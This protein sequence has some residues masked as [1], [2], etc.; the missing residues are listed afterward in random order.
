MFYSLCYQIL[1]HI[2]ASQMIKR[3]LKDLATMSDFEEKYGD[4]DDGKLGTSMVYKPYMSDLK[5]IQ[6]DADI[7]RVVL[8][9]HYSEVVLLQITDRSNFLDRLVNRSDLAFERSFSISGSH[10][11]EKSEGI[12]SL[13]GDDSV[14]I[15]FVDRGLIVRRR[16]FD[17][18][19]AFI[20]SISLTPDSY[21]PSVLNRIHWNDKTSALKNDVTFFAQSK[22]WFDKRDLP[23]ARSYLLYGPPGNGKTSAI[24]AISKYFD[25]VTSDFSFTAS[26]Q[27][28]DTCFTQWVIGDPDEGHNNRPGAAAKAAATSGGSD[29][30]KIRILL[31]EDI[32]RFFSK[33]ETMK[34]PVSLSAIL[35]ALDGVAERKNS[36]IIA[37]ANNPEK[38]DSQVLCRPGR[39][40][41]RVPFE[42]PD[43]YGI[44]SFMSKLCENDEVSA[45][46]VERVADAAKGHSFA[47][48]KGIYMVAANKAFAR[49]STVIVDCDIELSTK[50][51]L[52]N[53][54]RDVKSVKGGAGF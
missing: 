40:D 46:A 33:D 49:K 5:W 38:I 43:R 29:N 18:I 41:L 1:R 53:M 16:D 47:F 26:Y 42:P 25:T 10:W 39:F 3:N 20:I 51:F 50:E 14:M 19:A 27:D 32:D 54:G 31:L 6:A 23:Y 37:T 12:Y 2:I 36:I 15:L 8:G 24:K 35:N 52:A 34:T 21:D 30:P 45:D 44:T 48:I 13:P 11:V 17:K 7:I 4:A 28:P 9:C 22:S